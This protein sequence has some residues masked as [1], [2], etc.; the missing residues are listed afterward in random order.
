MLLLI[1]LIG[2]ACHVPRLLNPSWISKRIE[3]VGQLTG[4]K[5]RGGAAKKGGCCGRNGGP[6]ALTLEVG[7]SRVNRKLSELWHC[8]FKII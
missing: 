3:N 1:E 6:V 8:I 7:S 5:N 2:V 4:G